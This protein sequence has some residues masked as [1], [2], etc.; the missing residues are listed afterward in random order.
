MSSNASA[1]FARKMALG[2][3]HRAFFPEERKIHE[4]PVLR[5][6]KNCGGV[7]STGSNLKTS[8]GDALTRALNK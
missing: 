5:A 4:T 1:N 8:L 3:Y 2:S 6:G 7:L